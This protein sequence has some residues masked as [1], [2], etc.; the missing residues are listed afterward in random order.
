LRQRR[1]RRRARTSRQHAARAQQ[2]ER[3][4]RIG[5]LMAVPENDPSERSSNQILHLIGAVTLIAMVVRMDRIDVASILV[6]VIGLITMLALS[7]AYNMWPVSPAKR[8]ENPSETIDSQIE[9]E[10]EFR[11]PGR[12]VLDHP[13]VDDLEI[14]RNYEQQSGE[15]DATGQVS[16]C[17]PG[18]C[19]E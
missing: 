15:C 16:F 18:I 9:L 17:I 10:A 14:D 11:N 3:V 13:T 5:V 19:A 12:H 4:R 2:G 1:F 7:A 6:Y 8:G